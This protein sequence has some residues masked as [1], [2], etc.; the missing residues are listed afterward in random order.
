MTLALPPSPIRA[1]LGTELLELREGFARIR[2]RPQAAHANFSGILHGGIMMMLLDE[3]AGISGSWAPPPAP[4]RKS[5]TVEMSTHFTG[6]VSPDSGPIEATGEIVRSGRNIF[7][8]RSE[9]RDSAGD[10]VA[11]GASTHLWRTE[12]AR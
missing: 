3:A 5:V 10:L 4:P 1:L 7:F 9:L 11:Y 12:T 6:K 2:Y 8:V